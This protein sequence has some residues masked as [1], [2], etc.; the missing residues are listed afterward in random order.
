MRNLPDPV[1]MPDVDRCR[2][3][4][5]LL[6][7]GFLRH[8]LH[9]V[10]RQDPRLFLT[11]HR[12]IGPTPVRILGAPARGCGPNLRPVTVIIGPGIEPLTRQHASGMATPLAISQATVSVRR[13]D[14]P[15]APFL[16][17]LAL[18]A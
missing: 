1:L 8:R 7:R 12:P 10:N 9:V 18:P 13:G 3:A 16:S 15:R 14:Q 11:D 2:D 6:A 4:A 5:S 17:D